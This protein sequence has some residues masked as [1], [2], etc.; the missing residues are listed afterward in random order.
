MGEFEDREHGFEAKF[1][2]DQ[3]VMF[4]AKARRDALMARWAA[5]QLGLSGPDAEAYVQSLVTLSVQKDHEQVLVKKM[6]ADF[7]KAKVSITER[8]LRK[9]LTEFQN[10]RSD[11]GPYRG[12]ELAG[13]PAL[14]PHR[15]FGPVSR[16]TGCWRQA[17]LS[18]V[19]VGEGRP[20]TSLPGTSRALRAFLSPRFPFSSC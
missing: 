16:L 12:Q 14:P 11:P 6:L 20:S 13:F 9:Q 7:E 18:T 15:L 3:E 17:S 4:K 10:S 19:M 2:H 1:A 5:T 8:Q